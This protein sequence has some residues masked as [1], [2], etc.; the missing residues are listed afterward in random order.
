MVLPLP[1]IRS[2]RTDPVLCVVLLTDKLTQLQTEG[3]IITNLLTS[4]IIYLSHP[5]AN[6]PV[7]LY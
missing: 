5:A 1:P 2:V 4:V 7:L 3:K 6:Q